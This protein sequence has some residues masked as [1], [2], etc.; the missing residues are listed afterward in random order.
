MNGRLRRQEG[1]PRQRLQTHQAEALRRLREHAYAHS[2]FYRR[3]HR[4]ST[5]RPLHELPVLTKAVMM[6]NF[7]DLV[8]DRA[9]HRKAVEEHLAAIR[10]DERFL[11]RYR[12]NATSGSTGRQGLFLF[13]RREWITVLVTF[14]RPYEWLAGPT[15]FPPRVKVAAIGSPTPWHMSRRAGATLATR[16]VPTLGLSASDPPERI[17]ARLNAWQPQ[18]LVTYPSIARILANEQLAGRLAIQPRYIF[19][20]AEVLTADTRRRSEEAWGPGRLFDAYGAT[21]SG[22]LAAECGHHQGLHL[23]EDLVIFE[24]VDRNNRPVPPGVYGEK[25]LITVLFGRTQPLIR[26]ELSDSLRLADRPC[27]CGRPFTLVTGIQGRMEDILQFPAAAGGE[28]AVNPVV[29][30]QVLDRVPAGEWQVVQERDG[31]SIL[32]S[33]TP[34]GFSDENL[35]AELS[36]GLAAQGAV[37]PSIRVKHVPAIPRGATGKAPLITSHLPAGDQANGS[38][39]PSLPP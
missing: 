16:L 34:E 15:Y 18:V 22:T 8:T 6:E 19:T 9:I 14:L 2:P 10:G 25:L 7:D 4:G 12:A 35:A 23:F 5:A 32:L 28:V 20:G 26:Y 3:F 1:W 39:R 37:P 38:G 13:D 30:D 17:V 31:L 27:P 21:E 29:F 36:R 24:V 11:G 33:G